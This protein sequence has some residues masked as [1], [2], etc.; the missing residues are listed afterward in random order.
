[1]NIQEEIKKRMMEANISGPWQIRK[2]K[3]DALLS[4]CKWEGLINYWEWEAFNIT[5]EIKVRVELIFPL[6]IKE[7]NYKLSD[8][9]RS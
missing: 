4:H 8:L 5:D 3:M 2:N 9:S 7:F 6:E 1:M